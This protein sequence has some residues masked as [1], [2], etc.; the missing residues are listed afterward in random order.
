MLKII[1]SNVGHTPLHIIKYLQKLACSC[2]SKSEISHFFENN[3]RK[4]NQIEKVSNLI[5]H[6]WCF[7]IATKSLPSSSHARSFLWALFN[8]HFESWTSKFTD[9]TFNL[10]L[11]RQSSYNI[12]YLVRQQRFISQSLWI[13]TLGVVL[14]KSLQF[15]RIEPR[16]SHLQRGLLTPWD[17]WTD[18]CELCL[19]V[20]FQ[21]AE[22]LKKQNKHKNRN[23][24]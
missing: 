23:G 4:G 19:S 9:W 12:L 13:F 6:H 15:L 1:F 2:N 7:T 22:S 5:L 24:K 18:I 17:I 10:Q 16:T 3:Y 21:G 11:Y 20:Q 8:L 14:Q